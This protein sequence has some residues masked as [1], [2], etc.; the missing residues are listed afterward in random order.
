MNN[1]N[2]ILP[3]F[4]NVDIARY[5]A[6]ENFDLGSYINIVANENI[7]ICPI[8]LKISIKPSGPNS[9]RHIFCFACIEYWKKIKKTCPVCREKFVRIILK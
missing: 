7:I 6:L 1:N 3:I 4:L 5:N 2:H 9:C 8:H